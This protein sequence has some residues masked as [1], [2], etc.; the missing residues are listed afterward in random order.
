[1]STIKVE[2]T[3]FETIKNRRSVYPEVF[4]DEPVTKE[5]LEQLLEMANYAPNHKLTQPWRFKVAAG[6]Q[7]TAFVETM[8]AAYEAA[9]PVEKQLPKKPRKMRK[10]AHKSS[11]MVAICMQRD[12]KASLP[13]WEE[14]AAMSMAVQ[15]IWLAGEAMGIGMY[16]ASPGFVARPE[17]R[18]FLQLAE[19][20]SCYGLLFIGRKPEDVEFTSSRTPMS[21]KVS[22]I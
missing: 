16:W 17:I 5:E 10:R 20:E 8:V 21:E 18:E 13:E 22:W 2:Q 15:N 1:M 14:L 7:K 19:G 6:D 3:V 4:T 11:F 12:P 9:V